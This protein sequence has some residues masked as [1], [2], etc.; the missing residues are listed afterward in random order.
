MKSFTYPSVVIYC[1]RCQN[2]KKNK[3]AA[4]PVEV[5]MRPLLTCVEA[6]PHDLLLPEKN[7]RDRSSCRKQNGKQRRR[8]SH[9][10]ST[11]KM[12]SHMHIPLLTNIPTNSIHASGP[13][14]SPSCSG[15]RL[16]FFL[17]PIDMVMSTRR[18]AAAAAN[19]ANSAE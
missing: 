17:L 12:H 7:T 14:Y 1:L 16:L 5:I 19:A 13:S 15:K 8:K 9:L 6:S 18:N 11:P 2:E 4:E 3:P 10:A